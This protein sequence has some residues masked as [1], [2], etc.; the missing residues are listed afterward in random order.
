MA[1]YGLWTAN[2]LLLPLLHVPREAGGSVG[3]SVLIITAQLLYVPS[4][5]PA[6]KHA[7]Y[8]RLYHLSSCPHPFRLTSPER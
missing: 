7:I 2:L 4:L 3:A 6:W 8:L 1:E 5:V